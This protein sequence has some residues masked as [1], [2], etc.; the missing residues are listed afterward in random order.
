MQNGPGDSGSAKKLSNVF[1]KFYFKSEYLDD[2][3]NLLKQRIVLRNLQQA[4]SHLHWVFQGW[5][6]TI[7][8][9]FQNISSDVH[10][11]IK[12]LSSP[13]TMFIQKPVHQV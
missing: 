7:V 10:F 13:I 6:K 3:C 1:Q 8:L 4:K 12:M 2:I 5:K 9:V 11:P